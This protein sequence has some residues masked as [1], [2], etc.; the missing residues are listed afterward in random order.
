[1]MYSL[2][3]QG[4]SPVET[5]SLPL[6]QWHGT[7]VHVPALCLELLSAFFEAASDI[8]PAIPSNEVSGKLMA[9]K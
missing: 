9:E 3:P 7:V 4:L 1:M 8:Y 6:F 5:V 2:A